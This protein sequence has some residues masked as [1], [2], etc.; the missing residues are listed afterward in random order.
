MPVRWQQPEFT[1]INMSAEIGGYQ[2]E[3]EERTPMEPGSAKP[4]TAES[5]R[6]EG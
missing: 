1:E 4:P 6:N 5:S 2:D 3:F